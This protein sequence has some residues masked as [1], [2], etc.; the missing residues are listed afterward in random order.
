M[1]ALQRLTSLLN[2]V[3]E[4]DALAGV[5]QWLSAGLRI[6]GSSPVGGAQGTTTD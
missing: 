4:K 3:K 6:K 2:A 5:A 1:D